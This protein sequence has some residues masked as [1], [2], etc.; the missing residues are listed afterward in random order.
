VDAPQV[1]KTQI[2]DSAGIQASVKPA[3]LQQIVPLDRDVLMIK[4]TSAAMLV[5]HI[6][7]I[8]ILHVVT[9]HR[10]VVQVVVPL[11][12]I[13]RRCLGRRGGG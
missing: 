7:L 10:R 12:V 2:K 8:M 13:W 6:A 11:N 5:V 3:A 9:G 4:T 1:S